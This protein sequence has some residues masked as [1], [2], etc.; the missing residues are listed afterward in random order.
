MSVF[1]LI[2]QAPIS[3][4]EE[5]QVFISPVAKLRHIFRGKRGCDLFCAPFAFPI[6]SILPFPEPRCLF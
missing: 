5:K 4:G 3:E 2:A 1:P 6:S